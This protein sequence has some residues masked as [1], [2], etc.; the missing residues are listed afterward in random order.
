MCTLRLY[1][2]YD[3]VLTIRFRIEGLTWNSAI[4]IFTAGCVIAEL[5]MGTPLFPAEIQTNREHLAIVERTVTRFS[6]EF[7]TRYERDCPGSFTMAG[8]EPRIVFP[9]GPMD[10]AKHGAALLRIH[11]ARPITVSGCT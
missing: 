9:S 4:D 10:K 6:T 3:L 5:Y 8:A 11:H 2:C 7:A 1:G